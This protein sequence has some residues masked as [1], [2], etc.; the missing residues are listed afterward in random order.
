MDGSPAANPEDPRTVLIV[1]DDDELRRT[2]VAALKRR[3]FHV[4]DADSAE[5]GL[6]LAES[7]RAPIDV[8]VLDIEL[9]DSWGAQIVP[10]L[11]MAHPEVKVIYTSGYAE[12]DPILRAG[13]GPDTDFLPKPFEMLELLTALDRVLSSS[14]RP[15]IG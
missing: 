1:D 5:R 13:I 8:A 12:S 3:G 9:P 4:V 11:R 6:Q 14:S 7:W 15:E 10:G 2:V